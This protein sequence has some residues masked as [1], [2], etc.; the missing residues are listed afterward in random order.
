[1]LTKHVNKILG[2]SL[3]S[4]DSDACLGR[5]QQT[6]SLDSCTRHSLLGIT[7]VGSVQCRLLM[8]VCWQN[9]MKL[10]KVMFNKMDPNIMNAASRRERGELELSLKYDQTRQLLLV[11]VIRARNLDPM[12]LRGKSADPYVKVGRGFSDNKLK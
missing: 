3:H 1:M 6:H 9:N 5:T 12:D 2:H 11:K 7:G 10:L 8:L 4:V